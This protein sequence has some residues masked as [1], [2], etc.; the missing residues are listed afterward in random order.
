MSL[1]RSVTLSLLLSASFGV[2]A[3]T[4]PITPGMWET[5]MNQT[6]PFTGSN[7][8][9]NKECVKETEFDPNSLMEGNEN[10]RIAD[11]S[12]SG[13]TMQ[14]SMECNMDGG[15][16]IMNGEFESNGDNGSGKMT[17]TM[18]MAG[19]QIEMQMDWTARRVGDC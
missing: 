5:T 1:F 10:C 15:Q 3:D 12:V 9:V 7:T 18:S 13:N 2:V 16:A 6:N 17:M 4:L 14:F 19:Q 8:T 11:S